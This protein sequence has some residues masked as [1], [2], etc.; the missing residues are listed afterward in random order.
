[1]PPV[2]TDAREI[3]MAT[4]QKITSDISERLSLKDLMAAASNYW[5]GCN[6]FYR[7]FFV[8]ARHTTLNKEAAVSSETRPHTHTLLFCVTVPSKW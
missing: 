8:T 4:I 1:M 7:N 3:C 6:K 5:E 2:I